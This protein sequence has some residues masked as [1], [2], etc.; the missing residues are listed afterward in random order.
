MR[1]SMLFAALCATVTLAAPG[2]KKRVEVTDWV[3]DTVT[4]TD[5]VYVGADGPYSTTVEGPAHSNPHTHILKPSSTSS[6]ASTTTTT[7]VLVVT[8]TTIVAPAAAPP[9]SPTTTTPA[10][11]PV[12]TVVAPPPPPT[13]TTPAPAP[14]ANP[15]TPGYYD[16]APLSIIFDLEDTDPAYQ[17]IAVV[18]HNVHRTNHSAS[19][20][21]WN[22]TVA[23]WAREKANVCVYDETLPADAS[24]VGMNIAQG[25]YLGAANLSAVISNLWYN[26]ELANFPAYNENNLDVTTAAFQTWGHFSQVV[27]KGTQQIGCGSAACA[28]D[29]SISSGY[30]AVCMYYP[31]GNFIGDFTQVGEPLGNPTVA[32]VGDIIIGL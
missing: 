22:D 23:G 4:V 17:A 19:S 32:Q 26:G 5:Y 15:A 27:W 20:V 1:S 7:P 31:P 2:L 13:T 29:T 10:P 11:V 21:T 30:F 24:G 25:T 3:F 8:P 16:G 6:T 12:M 14:V 9:P 28:P 18:H